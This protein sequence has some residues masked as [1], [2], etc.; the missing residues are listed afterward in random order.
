[1]PL[2]RR[3]LYIIYTVI[4]MNGWKSVPWQSICFISLLLLFPALALPETY[5]SQER[6]SILADEVIR[7][8]ARF[9]EKNGSVWLA[10]GEVELRYGQLVLLADR[11]QV[12]LETYE[13]IAMG[14]IT[15]QLP[16][17]VISCDRLSYN[18]K[19]GE[20]SLEEVRAI[21]RPGALFGAERIQ[22]SVTGVYQLERAWF[23]S[24][25]QS[26]PRWRFAFSE[27]RFQPE[28][29]L[30]MKQAVF[31]VKEIPV[32]YVPHL[33]Y[34]LKPR[35]TGFLFPRLGFNRVKGITLSQSFYWAIA[36]NIDSTVTVDWYSRKGTGAGLEF[37][38]LL[39]G[40]T[41]GEANGYFFLPWKDENSSPQ[42]TPFI[43]RLDHSQK[44]PYGFQLSARAD[45]SS[46]FDF[47]RE[48]ENN[49]NVATVNNRSY[50]LGLTRNWSRFNFNLRASKFESYF[51]L[52]G[53][54][55][56]T[57]YRP[58][59][60]FNMLKYRL[61]PRVDL[62]FE[63]GLSNWQYRWKT[64]LT[65]TGYDLGQAYFRP[66]L[67]FPLVPAG[68]LN[69]TFRAG[70]NFVWYFQSYQP[71]TNIRTENSLLT[72][73]GSFGLNLEG[74]VVYRLFFL[75]GQ[76]YL[77][78]LVVPFISYSFDTPIPRETLE[79]IISP[80][81]ILRNNNLKFGLTQHFLTKT[82]SSPR[83]ILTLGLTAT[84]FFDPEHSPIRYYYPCHQERHFSPVN[85]YL[86]YYPSGPFSLDVSTDFNPY[87]KNLLSS[88]LS[89]GWGKPEDSFFFSLN[90]SKYYQ[91]ITPD[92]FL[93][94]HQAGIQAGVRWPEKIELKTQVE[95]DIQNRKI[96]YSA[97]AG[98]YHYQCLDFSF[99]LRIFYYRSKPEAQFRFSVGLGNISHTSD[100]LGTLGF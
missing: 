69:L 60:S 5:I 64:E 12:N 56:S 88:R 72:A 38:Y 52:T 86:R 16:E 43:L 41:R 21:S 2:E 91:A 70:G 100:L 92:S 94:S 89:A 23:T 9:Q 74:P 73:Q 59:L 97:L 30:T 29:H 71:G 93:R 62:S 44:L 20:G 83:E 1:M 57:T 22:K 81:G 55:V 8:E 90:W 87:E 24:C 33:K 63:S 78:H 84:V 51:P 79:R 77:K 76:A 85:V 80:F 50:Q 67:S 15:L 54:K 99:D 46:S 37:R 68:W 45:Y 42:K 36:R 32:L 14:H 39:P 34:P 47:L 75:K 49:F 58:Q 4:V 19:T 96:L 26:V 66:S 98:T 17:E 18:L 61:F 65:E 6:N 53:Q 82:D 11:L 25:T 10:E 3:Q 40:G 31:R 28:D 27:A 7:L 48:F 13:L 95:V 35:A